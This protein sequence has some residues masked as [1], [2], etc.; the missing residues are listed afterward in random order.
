[1]L[2]QVATPAAKYVKCVISLEFTIEMTIG[3]PILANKRAGALEAYI[4]KDVV[5]I[6]SV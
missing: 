6:L 3:M 2:M 5:P 1:M 4:S